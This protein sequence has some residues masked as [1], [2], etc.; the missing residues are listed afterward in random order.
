MKTVTLNIKREKAMVGA[1]MPYRI[2]FD[3]KELG[4]ITIGKEISCEISN[5]Q[6]TLE[7]SMVGNSLTIHKIK[8]IV[9]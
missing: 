7:V 8:T 1:A 2:I 5:S 3:G 4:K 9:R 6:S